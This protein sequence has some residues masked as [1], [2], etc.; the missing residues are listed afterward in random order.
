MTSPWCPTCTGQ[1]TTT[2]AIDD[3]IVLRRIPVVLRCICDIWIFL[4]WRWCVAVEQIHEFR[5]AASAIS[6]LRKCGAQLGCRQWA[7][8]GDFRGLTTC[9]A[10][11]LLS[12][13]RAGGR[14]FA[15]GG[16]AKV[17]PFGNLLRVQRRNAA[18][19]QHVASSYDC[20]AIWTTSGTGLGSQMSSDTLQFAWEAQTF[21][22]RL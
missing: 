8:P 12:S 20:L 7:V 17:R 3:T 4:H 2:T 5:D 18:E 9:H 15:E 21:L 10:S 13:N 1:T 11:C 16:A 19:L 14:Q 22:Q 6:S